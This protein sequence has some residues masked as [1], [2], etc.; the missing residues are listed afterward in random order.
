MLMNRFETLLVNSSPRRAL[1]RW[2]EAPQL[3]KLGGRTPGT[4][5]LEIGARRRSV[6]YAGHVRLALGD[7]TDLRVAFGIIHHIPDRRAALAEAARVLA[8]RGGFHFGEV[9]ATAL[10]RPSFRRLL[11]HPEEDR[12]TAGEFLAEL[13]RHGLKVDDRW[14]TRIGGDYVLGV[15]QRR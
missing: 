10:A 2:Y 8:A 5:V 12:F 4:R 11:E 14:V 7:A 6:R 9:T 3:M 15:A 1:Q 13:P